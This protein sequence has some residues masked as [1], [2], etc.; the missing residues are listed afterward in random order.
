M[1]RYDG[2]GWVARSQQVGLLIDRHGRF[3]FAEAPSRFPIG[4]TYLQSYFLK[5]RQPNAVFTAYAPGWLALGASGAGMGRDALR[6]N[7][8]YLQTA[9]VYRVISPLPRIT[10]ERLI[11]DRADR[12]DGAFLA[13]PP[14]PDRVRL[15][16]EEI[17]DG[18]S[19]DYE[20]AARIERFLLTQ[21]PYDLRVPPYPKGGDA[22]DTFLFEIQKGYCSQFATAMAVMG[23]L[24]GLPTRVAVGYLPGKYN[25]LTGVHEVRFQDAHAWVEVKFTKH[26][27][28]AF[29]PT[30]SPNSPWALGF[31][32][33]G[34]AVG[35]Q[36]L[37][38]TG[39]AGLLVDAPGR[40]LGEVATP[41]AGLLLAIGAAVAVV[42]AMAWLLLRRADRRRDDGGSDLAYS[43]LDG[44]RRDEMRRIY[45]QAA[46][47][48][49]H[50][51]EPLRLAHQ[52]HHEYS[53]SVSM[54][55]PKSK[56][57]FQ[58]LSDWAT[59][60]AYDPVPLSEDL[61]KHA[62]ELLARMTR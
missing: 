45:L 56:E 48:L 30:P 28:V 49:R 27:W 9:S 52:T 15:L 1:D 13:I 51:C 53:S 25:S 24:V 57:A 5:L 61:L 26:G 17:V 21:Y 38:R 59:R 36:Q 12:S 10:P 11:L 3:R 20:R 55:D 23:R 22:V 39:F 44:A 37:L 34:L 16:A 43:R 42:A 62:R 54:A 50:G 29:D 46:G 35:F 40:A 60:A 2:R 19:T 32:D 14:I 33:T 4:R 47:R 41:Q 8:E 58:R 31:G 7:V 6:E 18:A